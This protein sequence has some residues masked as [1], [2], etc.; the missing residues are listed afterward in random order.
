M[1]SPDVQP[2]LC[3]F[4]TM[5][6]WQEFIGRTPEEYDR[7]ITEVGKEAAEFEIAE[8]LRISADKQ[9]IVDT[10]IPLDVLK[11][12]SNYD[13]VAVLVSPQAMSVEYFFERED[14]EKKFIKEQIALASEPV[15]AMENYKNCIARVNSK[16]HYNEYVNSG[17]FIIHRTDPLV[18]TKAEVLGKLETHFKLVHRS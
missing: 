10:N 15:K 6:S 11:E 17:F 2:N 12:I 5:K 18:D 16:E 9:V 3:Y 4:R 14:E 13:H 1:A 8:L 7:W